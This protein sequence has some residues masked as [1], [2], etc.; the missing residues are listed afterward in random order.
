MSSPALS[1]GLTPERLNEARSRNMYTLVAEGVF[2]IIGVVVT[3]LVAGKRFGLFFTAPPAG[4]A[5]ETAYTWFFVVALLMTIFLAV[6][7]VMTY[8]SRSCLKSRMQEAKGY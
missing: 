5:E 8:W 2:T 6:G 1:N 4:S 3:L 7:F